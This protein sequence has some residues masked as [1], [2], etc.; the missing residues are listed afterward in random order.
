M[1]LVLLGFAAFFVV[2]FSPVLFS[3][4]LLAAGDALFEH[5]PAFLTQNQLWQPLLG[6]GY[7]AF[8][9]PQWQMFYPVAR[10]F[11]LFGISGWN[12]YVISPFVIGAAGTYGYLRYLTK[13]R[14]ASVIGA[15]VFCAG[16]FFVKYISAPPGL[17]TLCW[18]P[19]VVWSLT[20]IKDGFSPRWL[21]IG[22]LSWG[23]AI[24]AGHPQYI[25]YWTP[26]LL[27]LIAS[28]S[29]TMTK[30]PTGTT[31][32]I[33]RS[34]LIWAGTILTLGFSIG[35]LQI[36][37]TWQLAQTSQRAGLNEQF[38]TSY[39][40]KP[41]E[42][43]LY[44]FPFL[45]GGSKAHPYNFPWLGPFNSQTAA[46]YVGIPT[47]LLAILGSLCAVNKR[48][49]CFWLL[50]AIASALLSMAND[51]P[52][53]WLSFHLPMYQHFR[54]AARHLCE[55]TFAVAI[56]AAMG[57]HALTHRSVSRNLLILSIVLFGAA[58]SWAYYSAFN[59]LPSLQARAVSSG[60]VDMPHVSLI[61]ALLGSATCLLAA[62]T[63]RNPSL[64]VS[65]AAS[66]IAIA[67]LAGDLFSVA[68]LC[69]WTHRVVA[70][71]W[72]V[73]PRYT[74]GISSELAKSGTRAI[75]ISGLN[76][77]Y[78]E[79]PSN[80][81][82][83]WKVPCV[84]I[85]NPLMPTRFR[86]LFDMDDTGASPLDVN[87][88]PNRAYDIGCVKYIF[89]PRA[90]SISDLPK[91][92]GSLRKTAVLPT[93]IVFQNATVLP[94]AWFVNDVKVM[95]ARD[96]LNTIKYDETFN[97]SATA[98]AEQPLVLQGA[99]SGSRSLQIVDNNG[100]SMSATTNGNGGLLVTSDMS[101]PGWQ[102]EID[103]KEVP[104]Y[105]VDYLLR[106]VVVPHGE[107]TVRFYFRPR[108][109]TIAAA[110]SACALLLLAAL[111]MFLKR[112]TG[113]GREC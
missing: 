103:G 37:P 112:N 73:P 36:L 30:A 34:Y 74:E 54:G 55:T 111:V 83:I 10:V 27:L 106:G 17:Q 64:R 89:A 38:F 44:V 93:A 40:F 18:L 66:L 14:S 9:D 113:S 77:T 31:F 87:P 11:G 107:H 65:R 47:L 24:L 110:I 51:G 78:F 20:A 63:F 59:A 76:S 60:G 82:A 105:R 71:L 41:D 100:G 109:L 85:Y 72:L 80:V 79:L 21:V 28:E 81:A 26:V 32:K 96:C 5:L 2:L 88:K 68:R 57:W 102:A 15:L 25:A 98:I 52:L 56:L 8:A 35:A 49:A 94:R 48:R 58:L 6:L 46:C 67:L 61:P 19:I 50:I 108:I 12:L 13:S 53:G 33:D 43:T 62:V 29:L 101:Y 1:I 3:K 91:T 7:P 16:G 99:T 23:M 42:F 104:V 97:P 75:S 69:E 92:W 95:N 86:E 4:D 90:K 70:P 45:L 39:N 22:T 84:S